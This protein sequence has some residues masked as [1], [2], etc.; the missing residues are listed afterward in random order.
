[1]KVGLI[2][3]N[4]HTKV[5]NFAS[6]LHTY[7]FQQFLFENGI[8]NVIIDYEPC[9]RGKLDIRNP[10]DYYVAHPGKDEKVQKKREETWKKLYKERE[11]RFD[12]LQN[13]IDKNYVQTEKCFTQEKLDEIDP[14]CDIYICVTDVIWKY[15]PKN[16]FDRGFFLACKS[17]E[18]KGKIAYAAS[19][20]VKE[21][22][23]EQGKQAGEYLKSF[24]YIACREKSL[25]DF[26]NKKTSQRASIVLDPVFLQPLSFYEKICIQPEEKK[27]VLVYAVMEKAGG[28]VEEAMRYAKER[29][30]PVV[31]ISDDA[32]ILYQSPNGERI[33]KYGIGIEEW[34]GYMQNASCIFTNSF[35]C[36]CFSIIFNKQFFVGK[37]NGDKVDFVLHLFGLNNRRIKKN[38]NYN[39]KD[40][41]YTVV[42]S[43]KDAYV[44]QSRKYILEA[45]KRTEH[46]Q[47]KK[48]SVIGKLLLKRKLDGIENFENAKSFKN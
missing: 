4:S 7:A 18:G 35:H 33:K 34:L 22:T 37:R 17:F 1:M 15:N 12:K 42:N 5:L 44:N 41:D 13:F 14:G 47:K 6:P 39:Q 43:L 2:S 11:D 20:G 26:V 30:L 3:I 29:N 25:A 45:I 28:L 10:Y 46:V 24:H 27:Y 31:D 48:S 21:Y 32:T 16:G 23:E 38:M 19:K 9:Y 8:D 40:I 36:C